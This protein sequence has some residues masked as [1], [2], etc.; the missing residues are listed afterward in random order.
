MISSKIK[1]YF[2]D[3]KI[4][5]EWD[6]LSSVVSQL[7]L[8]GE[9]LP[10]KNESLYDNYFCQL[11]GGI[12]NIYQLYHQMGPLN[13]APN[14]IR[15]HQCD[16]LYYY[17]GLENI[18]FVQKYFPARDGDMDWNV[19]LHVDNY[20]GGGIKEYNKNF[21]LLERHIENHTNKLLDT[22]L[23]STINEFD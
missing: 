14:E 1:A 9:G 8:I 12:L 13:V 23:K 4:A 7:N 16:K 5:K 15:I 2:P 3:N 17:D 21:Y 11:L 10:S 6:N 22:V 20:T 18:Q 19:L